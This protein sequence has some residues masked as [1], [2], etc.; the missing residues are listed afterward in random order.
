MSRY[1]DL[2]SFGLAYGFGFS[3]FVLAGV[4]GTD[5]M[6]AGFDRTYSY[7][8]PLLLG[9]FAMILATILFTRVGPYRFAPAS[10]TALR[11]TVPASEVAL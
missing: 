5:I 8:A 9:L 10:S 6:G 3:R 4:L 11:V 7:S 2:R 1:F